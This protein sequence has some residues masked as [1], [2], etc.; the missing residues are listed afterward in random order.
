MTGIKII[1]TDTMHLNYQRFYPEMCDMLILAN[2]VLKGAMCNIVE[3]HAQVIKNR[4]EGFCECC[5]Y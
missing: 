3:S 2:A 5:R 4:R 1:H